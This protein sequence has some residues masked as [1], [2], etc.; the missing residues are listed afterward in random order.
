MGNDKTNGV[1]SERTR[2]PVK[3]V[4]WLVGVILTAGGGVTGAVVAGVMKDSQIGERLTVMEIQVNHIAELLKSQVA[5][6]EARQAA[7]AAERGQ[8]VGAA[9]EAVK[10]WVNE[11]FAE[12][13]ARFGWYM[14]VVAE[15]NNLKL[16]AQPAGTFGRPPAAAEK[17]G[18]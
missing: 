1:F 3:L 11:R 10:R 9:V 16:P 12:E 6:N 4:A 5:A 17:G 13:W 14:A 8:A 15:G 18:P 2:V 7:E